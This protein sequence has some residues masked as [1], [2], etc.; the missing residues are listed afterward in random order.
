MDPYARVSTASEATTSKTLRTI[1]SKVQS[2]QT[3]TDSGALSANGAYTPEAPIQRTYQVV[4]FMFT[5]ALDLALV[6]TI[7]II[8]AWNSKYG[9][10]GRK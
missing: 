6:Q 2:V 3:K 4:R 5:S 8:K 10:T 7:A 1:L 9:K